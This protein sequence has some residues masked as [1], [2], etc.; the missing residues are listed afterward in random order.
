MLVAPYYNRLESE[1]LRLFPTGECNQFLKRLRSQNMIRHF[2][3]EADRLIN[4]ISMRDNTTPLQRFLNQIG[5]QDQ[6]LR[7]W[8]LETAF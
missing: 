7:S 6:E 8:Y 4:H 3:S 1:L 5:P 2:Y